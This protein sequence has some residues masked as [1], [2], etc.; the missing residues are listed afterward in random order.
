MK[1]KKNKNIVDLLKNNKE[2]LMEIN[3]LDGEIW[4][5]LELPDYYPEILPIYYISNKNRVYDSEANEF[6]SIIHLDPK[7]YESPYH[8]VRL[9]T[10]IK[11]KKGIKRFYLMHRLLMMIFCPINKDMKKLQVNHKDGDKLNND[12]D[13]LEWCTQKE[14]T[15]HA[16]VNGLFKPVSGE[17][18]CC[19]TLTEK[20]VRE[21]CDLLI[22]RK[23]TNVEIAK[24]MNTTKSIVNSISERKAWKDITKDYDFS[25]LKQ[26]IPK[27]FTFDQIHELC[28]Y[29]QDNKKSDDM[30]CRKF[31]INALLYIKFPSEKITEGVLSGVRSIYKKE[32][33]S[34]ITKLYKF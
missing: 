27:C 19:A 34:D 2:N 29:F 6:I 16:Y 28:K 21:I 1:N 9:K 14:N 7:L 26:R 33:Y 13:N 23:Y 8:K 5:K 3:S 10:T 11:T 25:M 30:S 24:M 20:Q 15:I 18:H 31:C 32:R 17:K 22:S 12:L 4:K